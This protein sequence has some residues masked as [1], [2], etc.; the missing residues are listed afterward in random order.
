MAY[1]EFIHGSPGLIATPA[2]AMRRAIHE[3]RLGVQSYG[4]LLV[5][6]SSPLALTV[7]VAAGRIVIPPRYVGGRSTVYVVGDGDYYHAY[8]DDATVTLSAAHATLPRI[9]SIYVELEDA[10]EGTGTDGVSVQVATGTAT[11]GAT[12]DN[13]L[14]V[15]FDWGHALL[16]HV[17]VPA[18]ATSISASDIRDMRWVADRSTPYYLSAPTNADARPV[19]MLPHPLSAGASWGDILFGHSSSGGQI[20]E[21]IEIDTYC[22]AT[23]ASWSI[24]ND[25]AATISFDFGC[26]LY[27]TS[28]RYICTAE[29]SVSLA[30][31]D[32]LDQT[33]SFPCEIYPGQYYWYFGTKNVTGSSAGDNLSG[34]RFEAGAASKNVQMYT[35]TDLGASPPETLASLSNDGYQ[36]TSCL[37]YCPMFT[38]SE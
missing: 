18:A 30:S 13:Q 37:P 16:A 35:S 10:Y 33:I 27:T 23:S 19:G 6:Q 29:D 4:D 36:S 22:N 3:Q 8:L 25:G 11:A 26:G 20:A 5:S 24:T 7:E 1:P 14:G 31:G 9:D 28:G 32:S 15:A 2:Y 34:F 21:L 12:L 38:F 17:L